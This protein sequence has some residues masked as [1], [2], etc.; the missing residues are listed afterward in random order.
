MARKP[1]R[2]RF[3]RHYKIKSNNELLIAGKTEWAVIDKES[4]RPQ[5]AEGIYPTELEYCDEQP[6]AEAFSKID[7]DF[8]NAQLLGSYKVISTDIDLYGHMNNVAYVRA[9]MG[10][11][12]SKEL[13]EMQ[14]K[15][16]EIN[17][18]I[19]CFEGEILNVYKRNLD[20]G[21]EIGMINAEQKISALIKIKF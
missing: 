8:E 1:E 3:N 11:F 10:M 12:S 21:I 15:S 14:I 20:N 2:I 4:G 16:F 18:R 13:Q 19:P 5:K 7:T 6:I 17:Y 9:I